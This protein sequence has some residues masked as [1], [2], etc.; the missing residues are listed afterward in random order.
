MGMLRAKLQQATTATDAMIA[1]LM[2]YGGVC[3]VYSS[4]QYRAG[5]LVAVVTHWSLAQSISTPLL[6]T[7][8]H[9]GQR[10]EGWLYSV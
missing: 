5:A 3:R 9:T 1:L 10:R 8:G 4:L 2:A 6:T 7:E